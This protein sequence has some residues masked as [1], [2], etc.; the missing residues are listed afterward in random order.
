MNWFFFSLSYLPTSPPQKAHINGTTLPSDTTGH[1]GN[2]QQAGEFGH[3]VRGENTPMQR[4][5]T[6]VALEKITDG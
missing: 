1:R 4:Q 3:I 6:E 5:K 2:C